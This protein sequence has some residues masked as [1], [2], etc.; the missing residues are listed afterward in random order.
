MNN[1][2]RIGLSAA[3]GLALTVSSAIAQQETHSDPQ[4]LSTADLLSQPGPT[5][6]ISAQ[7]K[8]TSVIMYGDMRFTNP[9]N[10][11]ATNP[12]A[13]QALVNRIGQEH[14]DALMLSGDVPYQ[15]GNPN[16]Y[17][18][19]HSETAPW[20]TA[21]LRVYPALGNHEFYGCNQAEIHRCLD[22]WWEA[23]PELDHR[24]W[25]STLLGKRLYLIALDSDA[26]LVPGSD[27][28]RWIE[29]Q[30]RTLPKS[31]RFVLITLHHPPVSDAQI[32]NPENNP[33]PNE[34]ALVHLLDQIT[35]TTRV[36]FVVSGA[37]THNYERFLQNKVTYLVSGGGGAKPSSIV[38]TPA[39]LYQ[40]PSFPN[41]HYVKLV[42]KG[43]RLD[44]TM[45]RMVDPT[46]PT[47]TWEAKDTWSITATSRHT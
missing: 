17:A 1:F 27:Q 4:L 11:T 29:Q 32:K 3:L 8:P 46:S 21:G 36:R 31:V 45:Y 23:F 15:G 9:T 7:H 6:V 35:D 20:R 13:R 33:R 24:R 26:P 42:L 43:N 12:I 18:V 19:Y 5:F 30:L 40:D 37:H 41:F 47:S 22:N 16:D 39:D 25:Y 28:G 14:P 34:L 2:V 10:I 38:R 44:C